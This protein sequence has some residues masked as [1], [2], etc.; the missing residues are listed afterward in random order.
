MF[1]DVYRL[2]FDLFFV[3]L[4]YSLSLGGNRLL[5]VSFL[6]S[7]LSLGLFYRTRMHSSR[8]RTARSLIVSRSIRLGARGL[9]NP[10]DVDPPDAAPPGRL[11]LG[12]LLL[13]TEGMTHTCENITFPQLLLKPVIRTPKLPNPCKRA[14]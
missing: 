10:L 2:F 1:F 14:N 13:W 5:R 11:P 6:E 9:P 3:L 8:M 12:R 7:I 4:F